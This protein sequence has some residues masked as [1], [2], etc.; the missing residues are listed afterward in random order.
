MVEEFMLVTCVLK[1]LYLIV[2]CY[3][4]KAGMYILDIMD[5]YVIKYFQNVKLKAVYMGKERVMFSQCTL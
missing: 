4:I 3:S 1:F 2:N 5:N